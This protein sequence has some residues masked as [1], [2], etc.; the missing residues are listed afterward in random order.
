MSDDQQLSYKQGIPLLEAFE[1]K[2]EEEGSDD[3]DFDPT[4]SRIHIPKG[5]LPALKSFCS[6]KVITMSV[7][8]ALICICVLTTAIAVPVTLIHFKPEIHS[9]PEEVESQGEVIKSPLD[10]REYKVIVLRNDLRVLLV[11]DNE[12]EDSAAAMDV[13]VGSFSNPSDY[14]G[15]AHFCE[16]MLF[17]GSEKYPDEGA[18]SKFLTS[19]GGYDNA[20]TSTLNTNYHFKVNSDYL[21]EGLDRFAQFF[22]SPI[23]TQD[24][25][26]REVNA[27]D[28]E[29]QKN[30]ENDGWR[31]WQLLKHVSNPDYPFHMFSTGS[32]ET[33]D[34]PDVLSALKQFYSSHYSANQVS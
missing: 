25:V 14:E 8:I 6:W 3:E 7:V 26:S 2:V 29:H 13:A 24:G 20:Y 18:Y 27:V 19:H 17:Y 16:H 28:A 4:A 22:I 23:L 31:L 33:L 21:R 15:L 12:T 34:K 9:K 1:D 11:S 10:S 32:L 30:L 5:K